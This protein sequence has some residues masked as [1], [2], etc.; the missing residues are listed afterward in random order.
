MMKRVIYGGSFDPFT[1]AHFSVIKELSK[2]FDE[3][4][5][6]PAFIS[7]FKVGK[8]DLSG[9]ERVALI[10]HETA[11]LKNVIVSDCELRSKETSYS[12]LTVEK[13]YRD[14]EKLYFALGSDGLKT[15]NKWRNPQVLAK[16][17]TFYLIERPYYAIDEKDLEKQREIYDIEIADFI[18]EQGSSSLLK[19]AV[20]FNRAGEIVS[21]Y[22][23][24]F[25][26]KRNLYSQYC[27]ITNHYDEFM[28]T[29]NRREHIYRTAKCAII[30]AS[31]AGV[32]T[33][34][35]V[36]AVLLHDIAKYLD[37][38]DLARYGIEMNEVAKSLPD[39][40]VH[41]ETGA[42]VAQ[43]VFGEKDEEVLDAI[44]THTTGCENM[45]TLQKIVYCAD[46]I[47]DGRDFDGVVQI[48][49]SVYDDLNEGTLKVMENTI[50]YL[51]S[52]GKECSGETIKAYEYLKKELNK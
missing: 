40:C 15:L 43:I 22:A 18:G 23:M 52:T 26:K 3:V 2:R 29:P 46:Y 21:E 48:R 17:C 47:E 50:K 35:T 31:K 38:K 45:S 6:V 13:Y 20:A 11:P 33:E 34:K 14:G 12:Y 39:S 41:Q 8:M 9:A 32:D 25:I 42:Q 16:K 19:V 44:R 10:V 30:L 24:Q 7:P 5:V 27:Y 1:R 37:E 36:K 49:Q 51:T 4:I 28:L